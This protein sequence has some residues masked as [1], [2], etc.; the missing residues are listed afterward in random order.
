MTTDE[1]QCFFVTQQMLGGVCWLSVVVET[2]EWEQ[3]GWLCFC[4]LSRQMSTA[5][6]RKEVKIVSKRR[7]KA[8]FPV[9]L[10]PSSVQG[11]ARYSSSRSCT[12]REARKVMLHFFIGGV[13]FFYILDD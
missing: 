13:H 6:E 3:S 7:V 8:I 4:V 5:L 1:V 10:L 2:R 9:I 12:T 11:E